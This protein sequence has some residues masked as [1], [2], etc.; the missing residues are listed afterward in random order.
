M[1]PSFG[2]IGSGWRAEFFLRIAR[3]LPGRFPLAGIVIRKPEKQAAFRENWPHVPIFANWQELVAETTPGFVITSVGWS[4]NPPLLAEL[5]EAGV[6]VLSETPVSPALEELGAAYE[7]VKQG[8]RIQVAEQ[9]LFRPLQAARLSLVQSGRLGPIYEADISL[10]HGYHGI[11]ILRAL[12]GVGL[13]LPKTISARNFASRIVAG[14]G[15][16]GPPTEEKV[17]DTS[18]TIAHL[19]FEGKLGVFDFTGDQYFSWI[20]SQRVLVRGESGE[21]NNN[22]VRLLL[23]YLTPLKM[24]FTRRDAGHEDN[25]EGNFHQAIQLGSEILY[26]NPFPGPAWSDDEIA[27]ATAMARMQDY[28][29]GGP[30][31]YSVAEAA[32]DRYLDILMSE[33]AVSGKVVVPEPQ[34]WNG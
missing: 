22:E 1:S 34:P 11:S 28:V 27:V 21:I 30:E 17:Q 15:R 16:N 19:E 29:Q 18:R 4:A 2:I 12:L 14:P 20:R 32:Q 9:L 10:A 33:A 7:L 5:A 13:E 25:L 3:D 24:D 6:A 23:D 26:R 8:A 31:F